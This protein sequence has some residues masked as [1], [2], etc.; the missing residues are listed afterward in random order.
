MKEASSVQ[1]VSLRRVGR[2]AKRSRTLPVRSFWAGVRETPAETGKV[3]VSTLYC[4]KGGEEDAE[5]EDMARFC[6]RDCRKERVVWVGDK[7]VV[8]GG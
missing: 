6:G 4:V 3:V 7:E 5:S 8:L 1:S 2:P